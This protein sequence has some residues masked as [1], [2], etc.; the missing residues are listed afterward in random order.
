[1][2]PFTLLIKPSGSDC[3][4]D[5]RYCFYKDRLPELGS[6]RQRMS[7]ETLATLVRG[8]MRLGFPKVGFAWQGGEPTLMGVEFF[9][10]A[11]DLQMKHGKPGQQISNTFQTNG[12]ALN[13]KWC[14]FFHRNK[15]LLG[16]SID[17]PE[18]FHNRYRVDHAGAGTFA[19]VIRG[20]EN[21]KQHNV[22]FSTLILLN[23]ENVR[24]PDELFDFVVANELAYLQFIPCIERDAATGKPADF[25][26][27]PKQY[28]D[29][30]CRLFDLWCDYGPEKL[31]IREFDSLTTFFVLGNQT[32][33]T[34]GQQCA[35][36]VV[37]E[38]NGDAFCCEFFVEPKWRLGNI[39]ETPL[40]E[41]AASATK[42]AFAEQKQDLAGE[43]VRC[44]FLK[45]CRGGCMKD[46]RCFDDGSP[47]GTNYFCEAY[48]QFFDYALLTLMDMAKAIKQGSLTRRTRRVE[49]VRLRVP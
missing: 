30:L 26:I 19:R 46:R 5:C 49:D 4:I 1:M 2:Q 45:V 27:T 42:Q 21:C 37:V 11:V 32:I 43:C 36:F 3:N 41:L 23:S 7:H 35:G 6:G 8:Y 10:R 48:K 38:H 14:R 33:C 13:E 31:N 17:G 24:H 29:F 12:I 15:F 20:I 28:G 22:E 9:E 16:I 34:Y 40:D 47:A 18:K 25:S 44:P 39:A